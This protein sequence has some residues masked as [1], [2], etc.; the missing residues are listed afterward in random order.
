[1]SCE[2]L[3]FV[4]NFFTKMKLFFTKMKLFFTEVRVEPF[5]A[6]RENFCCQKAPLSV[7][8]HGRHVARHG[9]L[10]QLHYRAVPLDKQGRVGLYFTDYSSTNSTYL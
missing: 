2:N 3:I 8:C 4:K 5:W 7:W 1:M 9:S 6:T 10:H